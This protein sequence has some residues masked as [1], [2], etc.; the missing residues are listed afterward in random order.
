MRFRLREFLKFQ[1]IALR[2][3]GPIPTCAVN[4]RFARY[5]K[6][7]RLRSYVIELGVAY[8]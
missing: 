6:M 4:H 7:L 3:S 1:T 2:K 5:F 8:E